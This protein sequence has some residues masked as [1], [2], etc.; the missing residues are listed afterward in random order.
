MSITKE[1]TKTGTHPQFFILI[2]VFFFWGF[3]AASNGIFIP[4]C[5][6]HFNLNQ[7]QSQL[8]DT[9]FYG[10]Y[11][12]GSLLLYIFSVASGI[13]ILNKIGY[14]NG[15]IL[16]LTIS[17]IG[18]LCMIPAVNAGSFGL[19]LGAFFVVAL[20]FSL[21]QTAAQPFAIA[22]GS[23]ESG[24]HRLNMAGGLNSFGTTIGPLV[25]SFLLFGN[26]AEGAGASADIKS[27]NSLYLIL[28]GVFGLVAIIFAVSK[29]PRVTTDEKFEK[30]TKATNSLLVMTALVGVVILLGLFTEIS[31]LA[32]ISLTI[33]GV[34]VILFVSYTSAIKNSDGWGA[35]KFPQLILGMIGIFIYVGTEVTIQSN[36]GALLKLPEFGGLDESHISHFISLYW[37]SMMIGRWIGAISVFNLSKNSKIIA[38]IL[39]PLLAFAVI[40]GVNMLRGTDVSDLYIYVLCIGVLI[41]V[42]FWGEEKPTK[43]LLAVSVLGV[44]AMLLGLFTTGKVAVFAFIS[45]GLCC[46]VMWS[47]IFALSVVGLGKYTSQGSAFLIMMILGGALIPPFQGGLADVPAIGIHWSYIVPI[48]GFLYLAWFAIRVKGILKSQG[49]DFDKPMSGGH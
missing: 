15:I 19:I 12:I 45:G 40:L 7:F 37:G 13:D 9:A 22:L 6:T 38:T 49:M 3:V 4:F 48:V 35:I 1:Q 10:A 5:K 31:S 18:A 11:Y 27:I 39:V 36:M 20:G 42:M 32:L 46:S 43:T 21:Q 28:A 25:V 30:T 8:I 41:A 33:I 16:G 14:K 24:A 34:L 23:P 26:V 17:I 47:C 44:I 2:T 29:L